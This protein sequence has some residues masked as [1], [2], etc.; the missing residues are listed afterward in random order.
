MK[1]VALAREYHTNNVERRALRNKTTMVV[2]YFLLEDVI[3]RYECVGKIIVD[4]K[5]LNANKAT[6]QFNHRRSLDV[7]GTHRV[8]HHVLHIELPYFGPRPLHRVGL[9]H[10][11]AFY[12]FKLSKLCT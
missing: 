11:H 2:C 6:E 1:Y 12:P 4:T 10:C 9:V 7:L 8:H 3:Y 5:E